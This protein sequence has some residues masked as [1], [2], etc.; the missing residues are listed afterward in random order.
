MTTPPLGPR[1]PDGE[2]PDFG[3]LGGRLGDQLRGDAPLPFERDPLA[4]A[5]GGRDAERR[6]AE[7]R[8]ADRRNDARRADRRAG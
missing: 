2:L 3:P 5:L 7:R 1:D 4:D 8:A 6:A